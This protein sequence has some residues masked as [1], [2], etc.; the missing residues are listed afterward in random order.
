MQTSRNLRAVAVC[1]ALLFLAACKTQPET[2]ADEPAPTAEESSAVAACTQSMTRARAC[3]DAFIPT[4]VAARVRL[5]RPSGIAK[6]DSEN[7]REALID[8]AKTEWTR[9][10]QD[11]VIA[12]RCDAIAKQAPPEMMKAVN[13]CLTKQSCEDYVNCYVPVLE[14]TL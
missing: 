9:D 10:S 2:K 14:P 4:L 11:D 12:S 1:T 13:D 3:T 5:D 8:G 6:S 7:G